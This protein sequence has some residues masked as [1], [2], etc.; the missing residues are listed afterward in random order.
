[1][2]GAKVQKMILLQKKIKLRSDLQT[3]YAIAPIYLKRL[4]CFKHFQGSFMFFRIST[5]ISKLTS[6]STEVPL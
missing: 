3:Q 5:W 2:I 4:Y 1:M 6:N